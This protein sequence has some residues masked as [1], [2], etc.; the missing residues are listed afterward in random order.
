MQMRKVQLTINN[1]CEYGM[2]HEEIRKQVS[3]F[4]PTYC[5]LAD[6]IG[7]HGTLH[8]HVFFCCA[9]PFRFSTVKRRFPT[10]H[11]EEAFGSCQANRDYI[12]KEGVW[13]DT[14]KAET[15]VPDTFLEFGVI[16]DERTEK[17][18]SMAEV[19]QALDN[20][21]STTEIIRGN[22]K[23]AF[24]CKNIDILRDTLVAETF[25]NC[26]REI[27]V[28]Y[29]FGPTGTG[30]TRSIFAAHQHKDVYRVTH[31]GTQNTGIRFDGYH[32]HPVLVF[33]EFSSQVDIAD[34]LNYLDR[35]PIML[36]ARYSDH[37]A[38]YTKVYITSNLPLQAQYL[39][40]QEQYPTVWRAFLRRIAKIEEFHRDGS[41]TLHLAQEYEK[42][43]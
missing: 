36:P 9:S 15:T 26:E 2:T 14:A 8:T 32:S 25:R 12:R 28:I 42:G 41:I 33:E 24:Q 30:K 6:E 40:V 37:P 16:P 17:A 43:D 19:I 23:F 35:Y 21:Q 4:C 18:P 39:H 10:A 7:E 1:P 22:P 29:K 5:C 3:R 38:C 13:A 27:E 31:Y 11:I 20:G 34:M